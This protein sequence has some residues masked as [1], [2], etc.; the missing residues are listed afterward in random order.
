M[1]GLA[2]TILPA[3]AIL[4]ILWF[5]LRPGRSSSNSGKLSGEMTRQP[6]GN[7]PPKHFQ[8]F[9]QIRQ[10]LSKDDDTYLREVAP[11]GLVRQVQRER[12]AVARR[13]LKGLR[14]DF[15]NLEQLGRM[16]AALSPVVNRRQE[17]ERFALSLNFQFLCALV[18]LHL[19]TG[20]VPVGQIESLTGIVGRLA[21]RMEQ[22]MSEINALSAEPLSGK[23][24]A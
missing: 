13:Y 22:A 11:P 4:A 20:R 3:I 5:V 1:S 10:A 16:I 15:S 7:A 2:Y 12:R 24:S 14:E 23:V 21:L 18:W 19:S 8:Y 17:A 6:A 9:P